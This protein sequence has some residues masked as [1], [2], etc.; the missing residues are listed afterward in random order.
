LL[1]LVPLSGWW[2]NSSAGFPLR[3]FGLVRLP[4]L[5]SY[6]PQLKDLAKETH[7]TLFFI[8]AGIVAVHAL[9]AIWHHYFVRNRTLTRMLPLMKP[10]EAR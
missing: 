7:E 8:L 3:W 6:N 2:F 10:K 5:G 1:V 4:A 9:A